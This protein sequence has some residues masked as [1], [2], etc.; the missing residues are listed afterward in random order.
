ME[1]VT[2]ATVITKGGLSRCI[3]A[4]T[5]SAPGKTDLRIT[6]VTDRAASEI[7]ALVLAAMKMRDIRLPKRAITADL[8]FDV[9]FEATSELSLAVYVSLASASGIVLTL[10]KMLAS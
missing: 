6:G 7:R 9:P 10:D 4:T 5:S 1:N 8:V 2:I 3:S